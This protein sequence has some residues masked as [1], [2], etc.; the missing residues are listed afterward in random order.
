MISFSK[1]TLFF[2]CLLAWSTQAFADAN[3]DQ[4][5]KLFDEGTTPSVR[6]IIGINIGRCFGRDVT[7]TENVMIVANYG[8]YGPINGQAQAGI[9]GDKYEAPDYYDTLNDRQLGRVLER[10]TLSPID[11]TTAKMKIRDPFGDSAWFWEL[12]KNGEYLV[13]NAANG[14]ECCYT[15]I[16]RQTPQ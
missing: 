10:L 4:A 3:Y 6:E 11:N 15:F 1:F 9:A 7:Y 16:K 2:F 13:F 12:R 5:K 8:P 14:V